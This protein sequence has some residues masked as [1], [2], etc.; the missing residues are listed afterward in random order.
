MKTLKFV[1]ACFYLIGATFL[2]AETLPNKGPLPF[3]A[4]DKDNNNVITAKEFDAIKQQRMTQKAKDGRVMRNAGN[5][6]VF[7]DID[8]NNDGIITKEELTI[9]QEKRFMNRMNNKGGKGMGKG[10]GQAFQ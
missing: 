2:I 3:E 4:Y 8:T 5:S 9:H 1:T 6:A 10:Q 7:S